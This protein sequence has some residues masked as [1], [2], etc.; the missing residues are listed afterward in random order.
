MR[1]ENEWHAVKEIFAF[2]WYIARDYKISSKLITLLITTTYSIDL[3]I[4]WLIIS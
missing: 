4:R 2:K 1:Y 3:L